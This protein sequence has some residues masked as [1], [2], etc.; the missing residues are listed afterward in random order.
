[1][2]PVSTSVCDDGD[3]ECP[4]GNPF[5]LDKADFHGRFDFIFPDCGLLGC[6]TM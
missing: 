5:H 2:V 1:M 3:T 4:V 6:D